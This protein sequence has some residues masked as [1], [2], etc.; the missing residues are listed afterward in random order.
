MLGLDR[1]IVEIA[2]QN[3]YRIAPGDMGR[4]YLDKIVQLPFVI[5]PVSPDKLIAHYKTISA[6]DDEHIWK[7]VEIAFHGNPR[8]YSRFIGSWN[9][10]SALAPDVGLEL[11]QDIVRRMLAIAL[12]VALKFPRLHELGRSFPAEFSYFYDR[13]QD[14]EWNLTLLGDAGQS[15]VEYHAHW[16]HVPTRAFF[17]ARESRPIL[18]VTNGPGLRGSP[19][20]DGD[21][22]T[23]PQVTYVFW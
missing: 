6:F 15:A 10:V 21:L 17:G 12:A 7:V 1:S 20:E 22:G 18:V 5:P 4:D 13:C 3:H 2:I 9:V 23:T 11:D 19:R 14:T 16:E 8:M